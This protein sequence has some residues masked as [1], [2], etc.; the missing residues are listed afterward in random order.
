ME[1]A[2]KIGIVNLLV[3]AGALLQAK[4]GTVIT[5]NLP[6]NTAIINIDARADGATFA[7]GDQSLWY[8][9]FNTG[10]SLLEYTVQPGTYTFRV[11][12]PPDAATMFPS[13]TSGQTNQINTAWTFNSP[14][15]TDYLVFTGDAATN[16]SLPQLFDG[17]FSNTNGG[18]GSWV[19]YSDAADA[20]AAASTNGFYNLI[21]TGRHGRARQYQ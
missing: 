6:V 20:Y 11:V 12:N 5:A 9:P 18:P 16:T 8:Q 21:R 15:A 17:A 14:W 19:F 4:A 2:N 7:N 3:G 13:L 10:G 1:R